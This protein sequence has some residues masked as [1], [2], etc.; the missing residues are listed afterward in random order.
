MFFDD[1]NAIIVS[2]GH[3]NTY[4]GYSTDEVPT[5]SGL[6]YLS[7][8]AGQVQYLERLSLN[9]ARGSRI[10]P[11]LTN[12]N[13]TS[14]D[15]YLRFVSKLTDKLNDNIAEHPIMILNKESTNLPIFRKRAA[16][17]LFESYNA[18][19]AYFGNEAVTGLFSSGSFHGISID[20]GM[21]STTITPIYDGCLLKKSNI[22][23]YY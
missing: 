9:F 21:Y 16:E 14:A 20:S 6:S 15:E 22:I 4:I 19:A 10:Q 23:R 11:L 1:S 5:Y 18:P 8:H 13:I 12:N 17:L 2:S 3:L 7:T